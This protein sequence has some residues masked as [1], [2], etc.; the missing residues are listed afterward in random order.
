MQRRQLRLTLALVLAGC[1][2][3]PAP[4]SDPEPVAITAGGPAVDEARVCTVD[5]DCAL[6]VGFCGGASSVNRAHEAE[7]LEGERMRASVAT[8]DARGLSNEPTYTASC[9]AGACSAVAP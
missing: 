3:A 8:C 4:A 6:V 1:G 5:S 7:A 2:A 9:L